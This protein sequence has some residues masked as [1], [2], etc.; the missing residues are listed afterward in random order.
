MI[1]FIGTSLQLQPIITAHTLNSFWMPYDSCLTNLYE[2]SLEFMN[3]IPFITAREPN[4]DHRLQGLYY[5][6]WIR[7][8]GNVHELLP[9]K[10]SDSTIPAFRRYLPSR[11]LTNGVSFLLSWKRVLASRCLAMDYSGFHA[12]CHS[13]HIPNWSVFFQSLTCLQFG[14]MLLGAY[15]THA[16]SHR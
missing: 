14:E 12:S 6:S 2:E 13:I 3:E 1:G 10:M 7:C 15:S 11:S 5:S 16:L 8:L 4:R 9:S